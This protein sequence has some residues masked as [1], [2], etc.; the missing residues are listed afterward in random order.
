MVRK[1]DEHIQ[2]QLDTL[3]TKP[4]CYLMKDTRGE[5][6]YVGKAINL[7]NRV[8][9][10]FHAAAQ[11]HPRTNKLVHNICDIEWIVVG[12]E[13]EALILEMTLIKKH[14]PHYNVRLKDDKRY[15]YIKVH[16]AEAYPK[17]DGNPP[18]GAGWLTLFWPLYQRVGRT[19][20]AGCAAADFFLPDLRS[21]D[22]RPGRTCLSVL[23]Y[24]TVQRAVYWRRHPG[25]LPP[26]D[27]RPVQFFGWA[28]RAACGS[29][30]A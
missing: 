18:D 29:F 22:H 13:L 7:R 4:G 14:R 19:P 28:S 16:W 1:A 5:V 23:R 26:D 20:D 2:A 24:Q 3:P 9:S 30:A 27:R 21:G 17:G 6:I 12:S 8:R 10:Y 15:P 25:A 11:E